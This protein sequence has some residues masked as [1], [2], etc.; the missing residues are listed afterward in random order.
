MTPMPHSGWNWQAIE[1]CGVW[2]TFLGALA[3]IFLFRYYLKL[4]RGIQD[5]AVEQAEGQSRP[6]IV[7]ACKPTL[8]A[9][10]LEWLNEVIPAE[11]EGMT[12]RLLNV[13]TG[14]A[15]DLRWKY[16]RTAG[17]IA[18][19]CSYLAVGDRFEFPFTV[20]AGCGERTLTCEYGS[21][22]GIQYIL[23]TTIRDSYV[24]RSENQK[25]RIEKPNRA[26]KSPKQ[27]E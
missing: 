7:I 24:V 2:A 27:L 15:F 26:R 18:G 6:V 11:M 16:Q 8:P 22:G 4:T 5:A 9:D 13:G 3:N 21:R 17:P 19:N 20:E 12:P 23:T 1:A 25:K 14:P 10:E